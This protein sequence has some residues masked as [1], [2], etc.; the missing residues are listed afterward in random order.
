MTSSA[1]AAHKSKTEIERL[2]AERFPRQDLP[3]RIESLSPP[4]QTTVGS[5]AE[6]PARGG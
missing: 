5:T 1:A 2:L 6:S 3:T 4:A